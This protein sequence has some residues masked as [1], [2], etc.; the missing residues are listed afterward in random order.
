VCV[1]VCV[2]GVVA[3][4]DALSCCADCCCCR[5]YCR[6]LAPTH[7]LTPTLPLPSTP[8]NT[9]T[10]TD[11]FHCSVGNPELAAKYGHIKQEIQIAPPPKL[12][13]T[14]PG[15]GATASGGGRAAPNPTQYS[16]FAAYGG[17]PPPRYVT[18]NVNNNTSAPFIPMGM[19]ATP[20]LSNPGSA[21]ASPVPVPPYGASGYAHSPP[22]VPQ[23][24]PQQHQHHQPHPPQPHYQPAQQGPHTSPL[25]GGA[26]VGG[27]STPPR[28]SPVPPPPPPPL[29][30][31]SSLPQ[32]PT[33]PAF[34]PPPPPPPMP[35]MPAMASTA[36]KPAIPTLPAP[37]AVSIFQPLADNGEDAIE[38]DG[39]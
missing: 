35:S 15:P 3:V 12:D 38:L 14:G 22:A 10:H 5:R 37:N 20:P 8:I 17:R 24:P 39:K 18:Y 16:A 27:S 32:A 30:S 29:P 31:A 26:V 36:A 19:G 6:F 33:R 28:A 1:D 21:A 34:T 4:G 13:G 23:H 11:G 2:C 25:G 7:R 9:H